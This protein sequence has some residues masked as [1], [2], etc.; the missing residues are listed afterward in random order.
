MNVKAKVPTCTECGNICEYAEVGVQTEC[1]VCG[2]MMFPE[3]VAYASN[4]L[5]A[6]RAVFTSKTSGRQSMSIR[7]PSGVQERQERKDKKEAKKW[8]E[9]S[10]LPGKQAC[11]GALTQGEEWLIDVGQIN[12]FTLPGENDEFEKGLMS[13][14]VNR[15]A[16][17]TMYMA[18]RDKEVYKK[19][20]DTFGAMRDVY[21]AN[22]ELYKGEFNGKSFVGNGDTLSYSF[23]KLA[24][25]LNLVWLDFMG[26]F[27]EDYYTS[28]RTFLA[29]CDMPRVV[30]GITHGTRGAGSD[31]EGGPKEAVASFASGNRRSW[32]TI[33]E[34]DIRY[35]SGNRNMYF[36]MFCLEKR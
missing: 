28:I 32:S 26:K 29:N 23:S 36:N 10:F 17:I 12:S 21:I 27:S 22:T 34:T 3:K 33:H 8:P 16:G 31:V 4:N 5:R 13:R 6:K 9:Y 11:Y 1:R 30:L 2:E 7:T 14:C 19:V 35:T 18:E 25:I 15:G 24:G 20:R